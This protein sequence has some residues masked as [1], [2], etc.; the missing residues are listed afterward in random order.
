[1]S[2]SA[3][4]LIEDNIILNFIFI[5]KNKKIKWIRAFL[6]LLIPFIPSYLSAFL[7]SVVV[8]L[9]TK[10][11]IS[12]VQDYIYFYQT[13]LFPTL[14][15]SFVAILVK[16]HELIR[17][18]SNFIDI[19]ALRSHD[20]LNK[21]SVFSEVNSILKNGYYK[22]KKYKYFLAISMIAGFSFVFH[23]AYNMAIPTKVYAHDTWNS[24]NYPF[25]Y[26]SVRFF[27][28]LVYG[29][30]MPILATKLFILISTLNNLFGRL[31]KCNG[32]Y[33]NPLHPDRAGG[34]GKLG[35][36]A[37]RLNLLSF[38]FIFYIIFVYF[39]FGMY[40]GLLISSF[41]IIMITIFLFFLPLFQ[42]HK[43]MKNE[44][45]LLLINLSKKYEKINK[46]LKALLFSNS[47]D[48]EYFT[49]K[50]ETTYDEHQKISDIY[51]HIEKLPTWP[52]DYK[53]LIRF[54]GTLIA[55]ITP[56]IIEIILN[57]DN[58]FSNLD[59]LF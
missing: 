4:P 50:Y 36:I 44:K 40:F 9:P 19:E 59:K 35:K 23:N 24:I 16:F 57:S 47:V 3:Y 18:A 5:G 6:L 14:S 8:T 12:L 53:T 13:F 54:F 10:D 43:A 48:T 21:T 41:V 37:L 45:N 25:C 42:S 52:Y 46:E 26:V 29:I 22:S 30:L 1:M 17:S 51:Q 31:K 11:G 15:I 2:K 56:I 7:E 27:T 34:L 20:D 55:P 28:T 33:V 49:G 32:L 39:T 58:M 38:F